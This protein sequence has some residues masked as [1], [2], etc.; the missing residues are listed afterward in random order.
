MIKQ[1]SSVCTT[2]EAA[3]LLG[4]SVTSVQQLVESGALAAWK[5]QGGHRRIPLDAV[6]QMRASHGLPAPVASAPV[7]PRISLMVVEDDPLLR[8]LYRA[9]F[10]SWGLPFDVAFCD[11]GFQALIEIGNQPPDVL[12]ADILM[13]GIDGYEVV[14]TVLAKPSLRQ[15]QVALVSAIGAE[16]LAAR[17]GVPAGVAFFPKPVPFERLHGYLQACCA[18]KQRAQR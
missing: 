4:M 5:T 18:M 3:R 14:E 16:E 10:D 9:R 8:A 12:L 15:M 1:A 2:Q 17:G 13:Q 11:N 7:S 6:L